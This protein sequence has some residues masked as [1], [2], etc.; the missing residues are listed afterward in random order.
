MEPKNSIAIYWVGWQFIAAKQKDV[1]LLI[2]PEF[3]EQLRKAELHGLVAAV[4]QA[5]AEE[6]FSQLCNELIITQPVGSP[7]QPLRFRDKASDTLRLVPNYPEPWMQ[8]LLANTIT[9][10]DPEGTEMSWECL[11]RAGGWLPKEIRTSPKAGLR[12]SLRHIWLVPED[13]PLSQYIRFDKG[14]Y[15]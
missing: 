4:R 1:D 11:A 5:A 9:L 8:V 14:D 3:L 2:V 7:A 10:V 6:T 13:T 15:Q 12:S